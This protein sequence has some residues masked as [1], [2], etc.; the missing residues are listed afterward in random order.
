MGQKTHPYGFRLGFNRTWKSR[1]FSKENYK[2]YLHEDLAIKRA[3][4]KKGRNAG[5]SSIEIERQGEIVTVYIHTARPGVIIGRKGSEV[6]KLRDELSNMV[7]GQ[8]NIEIKEIQNPETDAQLIAESVAQQLER[9]VSFR[10]AMKRAVETAMRF[11]AL[12]VKVACSGRLGGVEMARTEWYKDGRLPLS[13][14]RADI[15]YGTAEAM[16]QY[17]IIGVKAWVYKGEMLPEDLTRKIT[18]EQE[19]VVVQPKGSPQRKK[20]R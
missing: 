9:R 1:W 8:V 7:E 18:P 20:K 6:N 11:G 19:P 5:I 4:E 2:R 16:T 14:L 3:I 12:G 13:T 15:D 10:R 17:G